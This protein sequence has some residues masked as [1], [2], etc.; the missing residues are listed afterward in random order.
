MIKQKKLLL[1]FT[2]NPELGKVKTR[3]AKDIGDQKALD[4]Y[5]FLINHTVSVTKNLPVAKHVYYSVQIHN[6]D[7]WNE[8]YFDKRKQHGTDLGIRM[9]NAFQDSFTEGYEQVIII[10]S[11]LYDITQEEITAAFDTLENHDAVI[12]PA[13]DG[14]YYLL[15]LKQVIPAV[16]TNKSW[17]TDTVFQQTKADLADQNTAFLSPKNDVDY[18]SDIKNHP[19][20]RQFLV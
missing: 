3:L 12:G 2:R 15:G 18:L 11:D 10:G 5:K 9:E 19:A 4:I 13:T 17:G 20:F 8:E 7:F 16:F 1:I 6:E 14:G